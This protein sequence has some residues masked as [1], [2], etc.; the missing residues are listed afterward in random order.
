MKQIYRFWN[1]PKRSAWI[2]LAPSLVLLLM[3]SVIPMFIGLG[4]SLFD[5]PV[6]MDTAKFVGLQNFVQA[7]H[8]KRF[9]NS[10]RVTAVFTLIEVP[11]QTFGAMMIAALITKNN[12]VNKVLRGIYFLPVICSATAIG[13]MWKMIL[14]SNIGFIPAVL[15]SFG[16]GKINFLNTPGLTIFVVTFISIWRSFGI[17]AIVYVTAIQQV[18]PSLYEAAEMDGAGK[19]RQFFSI[20]APSIRPTFWYILMTRLAGSLQIFD[21]IYTTTNG[22]P[23]YTTE[24]T[25]TYIYN[26]AFSTTS[27]MGYASAMSVILFLIIMVVTVLLYRRMNKEES[28]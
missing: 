4:L 7:F 1:N 28:S 23:N 14:H 6:T 17:S 22:G 12:G 9:L 20:T 3:F 27:S 21:I 26:R 18:S 13:I 8:D 19:I 2:F 10:L 16:L 24:S 11:I 25:V 15:Q 5:V